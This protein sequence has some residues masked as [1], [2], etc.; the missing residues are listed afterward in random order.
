M[1]AGCLL[2]RVWNGCH[3]GYDRARGKD[4]PE[5]FVSG[6]TSTPI[7]MSKIRLEARV[8]RVRR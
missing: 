4:F 6:F 1:G 3:L 8:R 5:E 2:V 7:A